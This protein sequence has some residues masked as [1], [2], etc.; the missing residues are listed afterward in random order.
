M[1]C[2]RF[3]LYPNDDACTHAEGSR[4][5]AGQ[6][7]IICDRLEL[8]ASEPRGELLGALFFKLLQQSGVVSRHLTPSLQK[9]CQRDSDYASPNC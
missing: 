5:F 4:N 7:G 6:P 2:S 1:H 9:R 3:V 8:S